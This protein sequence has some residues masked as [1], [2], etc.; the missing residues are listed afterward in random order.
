MKGKDP[1]DEVTRLSGY[2]CRTVTL[3]VPFVEGERHL[4]LCKPA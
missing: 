1:S 3:D 2:R 4:V